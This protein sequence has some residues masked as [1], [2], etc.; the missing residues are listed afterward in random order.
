[1]KTPRKA[2]PGS[3]AKNPSHHPIKPAA[4]ML[5]NS[6][7]QIGEVVLRPPRAEFNVPEDALHHPKEAMQGAYVVRSWT[8]RATALSF[9]E[10]RAAEATK[11]LRLLGVSEDA[12]APRTLATLTRM[13]RAAC[14][15]AA[16]AMLILSRQVNEEQPH[17]AG[18]YGG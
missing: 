12:A 5:E 6:P 18:N 11:V 7:Q 2:R 3:A 1:M 14:S 15:R 10:R 13:S 4:F 8:T 17:S 9:S 16:D